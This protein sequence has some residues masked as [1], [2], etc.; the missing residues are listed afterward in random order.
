MQQTVGHNHTHF[1]NTRS[2]RFW[3]VIVKSQR[4]GD[5]SKYLRIKVTYTDGTAKIL[6]P[7]FRD[8]AQLDQYVAR[9]HWNFTGKEYP[10]AK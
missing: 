3:E 4:L 10:N 8:R 2:L 1:R 7:S 9:F 5:P 6:A